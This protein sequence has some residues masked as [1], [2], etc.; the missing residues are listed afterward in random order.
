MTQILSTCLHL[1]LHRPLH[2]RT[3]TN[4][5]GAS[6]STIQLLRSS[7]SQRDAILASSL[8]AALLKSGLRSDL[9]VANAL[10]DAYLK[11][12]LLSYAANLFDEMPQRDV[13][14]WTSLISGLARCNAANA[15][16]FAFLDMLGTHGEAAANDDE[17]A[18]ALGPSEFTVSALLQACGHVKDVKLGAMAHAYIVK[19]GFFSDSFVANSLIDMYAKIGAAENAEKL[20][21]GL[22]CRGVV[23][24]TAALSGCVLNGMFAKALEL[25]TMMLKDGILPNTV[26]MLSIIQACSLS[27]E[28]SFLRWVHAWATKLELDRNDLIANSLIEMYAKNGFLEEGVKAFYMFYLFDG[29]VCS[30]ASVVAAIVHGCSLSGS[31]KHVK[32][33]HGYLTKAGF[34]PCTVIENSIMGTYAKHGRVDDAHL[35]FERMVQRDTVSWNTVISCFVKNDRAGNALEFLG[36]FHKLSR[37]GL[38]PDFVTILSS[39]QA[40]SEVASL[41]QGQVL[42]S[43]V[44]KSGFDIDVYVCNALIDMYAKSGRIDFAELMFRE[45]GFGFKDISSWNSM[46]AA[47]GIHRD[48][49]SALRVFD[50][51]KNEGNHSPNAVTFACVISACGHA[52]FTDEGYECFKS[53]KRDNGIEPHTEHCASMVNLFGRSGKLREAAEFIKDMP[54]QP[55]P[56]VWGAL[57]GACG[58]HRNIEIAEKAAKELA[59]LEPESDIWKVSLSNVYASVG[60]WGDWAKVRASMKSKGSR[61]E[62]GWSSVEVRG[63][64]R[65]RFTV[66]DTRHPESER[67]YEVWRSINKHIADAAAADAYLWN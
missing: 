49:S 48:G 57:L 19:N 67:I 46:I 62:A 16:V 60:K 37:I 61:K 65:Y 64:E 7:A 36:L 34:F 2:H 55:G 13:A 4:T 58:L 12:G 30:D 9:F 63:R 54:I 41:Q 52:G 26:T 5:N 66:A 38:R 18:A 40:C 22:R 6:P 50:R 39:I 24:W 51:L 8:H 1:P 59:V 35:V 15:A 31:L 17:E 47:Y 21:R 11:N 56:S 53:M 23:S 3:R 10:L 27:G 45:I 42:H 25:F 32:E 43:Y 29:K 28:P 14:S 20:V 33:I 44:I